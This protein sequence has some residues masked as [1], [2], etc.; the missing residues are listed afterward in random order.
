MDREA[1]KK[2]A[3]G[4][5]K[6]FPIFVCDTGGSDIHYNELKNFDLEKNNINFCL[7][8]TLKVW[9]L[10]QNNSLG[11]HYTIINILTNNLA[12]FQVTGNVRTPEERYKDFRDLVEEEGGIFLGTLHFRSIC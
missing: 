1:L 8:F 11:I 4:T 2:L 3:G 6:H 7:D 10:Y 12:G 5:S 9:V